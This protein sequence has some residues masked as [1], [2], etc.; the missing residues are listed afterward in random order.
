MA[1]FVAAREKPLGPLGGHMPSTSQ[2]MIAKKATE[3]EFLY[4][5]VCREGKKHGIPTPFNEAMYLLTKIYEDTY[6]SKH[7]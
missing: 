2:D 4:G 1:K 3:V 5:A 6:S 7:K